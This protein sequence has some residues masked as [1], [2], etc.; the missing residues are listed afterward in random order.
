MATQRTG[1]I[2]KNALSPEQ[3]A[4]IAHNAPPSA[5]AAVRGKWEHLR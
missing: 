5:G 3:R 1:A 4:E 2:R